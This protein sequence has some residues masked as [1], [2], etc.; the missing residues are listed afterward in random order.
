MIASHYAEPLARTIRRATPLRAA[1]GADAEVLCELASGDPFQL[2]DNSRG[3][4]WGYAG[5]ERLVGYVESE[6]LGPAS[7]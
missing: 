2:L 5:T 4:G 1:A 7:G 6:A 3:W